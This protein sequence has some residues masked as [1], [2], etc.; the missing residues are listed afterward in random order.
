[1]I[2][3]PPAIQ[4]YGPLL[5]VV[6][7]FVDGLL[8]GLAIKKA[9]VSFII[10]VVAVLLGTYI[11][12]SLPGVSAQALMSRAASLVTRWISSAP[13]IF[14]GVSIFFIIGIAIGIWKG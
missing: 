9:I 2:A 12:I 5:L 10:F 6:L 13:A 4:P 8:F 11:G 3:L 14:S 1:M 7:A